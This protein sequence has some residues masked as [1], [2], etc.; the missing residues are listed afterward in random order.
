[1]PECR[2]S[3]ALHARDSARAAQ[4]RRPVAGTQAHK[5]ESQDKRGTAERQGSVLFTANT[6]EN[7]PTTV[8][9]QSR[10]PENTHNNVLVHGATGERR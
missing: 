6:R 5:P 1:M 4:L 2:H 7:H 3:S 9:C 10:H 8:G